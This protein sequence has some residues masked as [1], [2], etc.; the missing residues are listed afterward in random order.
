MTRHWDR[1]A[2]GVLG[3]LI[4]LSIFG[5]YGLDPSH[6]DWMAGD[7]AQHY[8]GWV[9][10]RHESW[11][12]PLGRITHF[13]S[14]GGT[15]LVFTDSLPLLALPL[16]LVASLLP[17]PFQFHGWWLLLCFVL[18]GIFGTV[19]L[20]TLGVTSRAVRVTGATLFTV[21]P[22][23]S[24]HISIMGQWQLL[25]A[26][27]CYASD[28]R[29]QRMS[30]GRWCALCVLALFTHFYLWWMI[31]TVA[32]A[33][34]AREAWTA[35]H[36]RPFIAGA[37]RILA[38][39]FATMVLLGYFSGEDPANGG[40]GLYSTNLNAFFDS[41]SG[42]RWLPALG[43]NPGQHEG[44]AYFG[45]AG[46][47]LLLSAL[48]L[49]FSSRRTPL[50]LERAQ[51][52]PLWIALGYLYFLALSTTITFGTHV[53]VQ[54]PAGGGV[55]YGTIRAAGRFVFLICDA[56]LAFAVATVARRL[57]ARIAVAVFAVAACMQLYELTPLNDNRALTRQSDF[58]RLQ[59]PVWAAVANDYSQIA[60]YPPLFSPF[61]CVPG[62][63]SGDLE[64]L[65]FNGF[66]VL[67]ADR[68][69]SIN[70]AYLARRDKK[71]Q[72]KYCTSFISGVDEG[73]TEPRTLYVVDEH[74]AE[75]FHAR[76]PVD[77]GRIDGSEI[78]TARTDTSALHAA[79][80]AHP[81]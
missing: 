25:A 18:Q 67:A 33:A 26:L 61:R 24:G 12:L 13:P 63:A 2:A 66:A 50:P 9:F 37:S 53:L 11:A 58:T 16:R 34:A 39:S 22:W 35:R 46:L 36:L 27:A 6:I 5:T 41:A 32:A 43:S 29:A 3:G 73:V 17:T 21:A 68:G 69:M 74:F 42:S 70:S 81:L 77:C 38:A 31:A 55:F 44:F 30:T 15:S 14:A 64:R 20:E 47:L 54:L 4:A 76:M 72:N 8:L 10:F 45:V 49:H 40:F 71:A 57:P 80:L 75:R 78:C 19:L 28:V 23:F 51:W 48:V 60:I 59:D 7:N 1:I 79:L 65:G 56:L 62:A 52:I